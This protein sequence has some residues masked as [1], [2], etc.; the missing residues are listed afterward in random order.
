MTG[1]L[2]I[3]RRQKF[4]RVYDLR[5]RVLPGWDD[6]NALSSEEMQPHAG[7]ARRACPRDRPPA[8]VAEYYPPAQERHAR[9]AGALA[10][11]GLLLPVQVEGSPDR[12]TSTPTIST[13][14]KRRLRRA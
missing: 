10:A 7:P 2:M 1:E 9:P 8:W 14:S 3:A 6:A 13:C 4:Q 11:E 12:L 5:E